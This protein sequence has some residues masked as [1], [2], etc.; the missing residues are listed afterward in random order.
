M[1]YFALWLHRRTERLPPTHLRAKRTSSSMSEALCY[2]GRDRK[3]IK[4]QVDRIC[5]VVVPARVPDAGHDASENV[6]EALLLI[7]IAHGL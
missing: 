4:A 5:A 6:P 2:G 3:M 1:R 7:F